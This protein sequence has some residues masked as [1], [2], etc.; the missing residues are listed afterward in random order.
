[1]AATLGEF[2]GI[3]RSLANRGAT[4]DSAIPVYTRMAAAL[5]EKNYSYLYMQVREKIELAPDPLAHR[6][7]LP[8]RYKETELLRLVNVPKTGKYKY[9]IKIHPQDQIDD[10]AGTPS[11]YYF[12]AMTYIWLDCIIE[13]PFTLDHWFYRFTQWPTLD[14]ATPWLVTDAEE[15]LLAATMVEL[16]PYARA[17]EWIETYAAILQSHNRALIT[18]QENLKRSQTESQMEYTGEHY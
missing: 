17:P 2:H 8:V 12:E 6:L 7:N 16:A 14:D 11:A 4:L 15:V 3:I 5:L 10:H 9:L 1:M 18:A 13:A